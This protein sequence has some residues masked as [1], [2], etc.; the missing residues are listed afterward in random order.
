VEIVAVTS[1]VSAT[2]VS[3]DW[4]EAV[5]PVRKFSLEDVAKKVVPPIQATLPFD[6]EPATLTKQRMSVT[7]GAL[8]AAVEVSAMAVF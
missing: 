7:K 5:V 4:L 3:K 2:V 6:P 1:I 8:T